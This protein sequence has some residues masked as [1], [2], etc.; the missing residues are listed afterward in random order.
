VHIAVDTLGNLLAAL[1]T[2]ANEQ[3]RDQVAALTDAV[4]EATGYS[5]EVAV[6]VSW[7]PRSF[8]NFGR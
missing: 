4:Q 5:V 6:I 1:V 8:G 3:E 2:P 7:P